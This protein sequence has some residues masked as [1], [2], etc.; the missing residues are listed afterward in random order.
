VEAKNIQPRGIPWVLVKIYNCRSR[1]M[2]MQLERKIK[3]RG[4]ERFIEE[5]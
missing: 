2:A 5:N 4:I 3:K 1:S